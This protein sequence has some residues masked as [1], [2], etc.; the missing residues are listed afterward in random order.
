MWDWLNHI[1][2]YLVVCHSL[3][4]ICLLFYCRSINVLVPVNIPRIS[5]DRCSFSHLKSIVCRFLPVKYTYTNTFLIVYKGQP[6]KMYFRR[7]CNLNTIIHE[8]SLLWYCNTVLILCSFLC[9]LWQ[10]FLAI[11]LWL[12]C[13][14][15]VTN[16]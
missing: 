9:C 3:F 16:V 2:L 14:T 6:F 10:L 11:V 8:L 5:L 1:L 12:L 13:V 7:L 15:V 4:K